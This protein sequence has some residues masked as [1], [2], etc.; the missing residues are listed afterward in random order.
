M[1]KKE[2]TY[3]EEHVDSFRASHSK[4]MEKYVE[5]KARMTSE[6]RELIKSHAESMG[7]S[8]SQFIN[9]AID[10]T[11]EHDNKKK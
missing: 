7:E 5:I 1:K 3:Y 6:K 10:E 4:Y 8:A 11:I 9:R 2:K